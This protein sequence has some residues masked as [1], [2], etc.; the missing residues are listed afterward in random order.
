MPNY[1]L[2]TW[3]TVI[4]VIPW[5]DAGNIPKLAFFDTASAMCM[6]V[7]VYVRTYMV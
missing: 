1:N 2:K 6:C 7:C 5:Y 3:C 4:I